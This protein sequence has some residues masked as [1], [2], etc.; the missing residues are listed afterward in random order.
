MPVRLVFAALLSLGL[1]GPAA[2]ASEASA[3]TE[4]AAPEAA[5][6]GTAAARRVASDYLAA[7]KAKKWD[8]ARKQLHPRRLEDLSGPKKKDAE[9]HAL[10]AWAHLKEHYLTKFEVADA[11]EAGEG[12][13]VVSTVEDH[14][15]VEDKG[16]DE[17]VKAEYLLLALGDRW[18]V[19]DR[20]LGEGVFPVRNLR[21]AYKEYFDYV[22]AEKP[23]GKGRK[24]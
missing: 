7:V 1:A 8:V 14:F 24:H 20:R 2:S 19:V 6:D 22:P 15:S 18:F 12:A 17:G 11:A 10:A 9:R 5:V 3:G 23:A 21:A 16:S 4:T 13:V